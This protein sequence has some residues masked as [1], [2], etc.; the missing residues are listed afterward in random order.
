[1]NTNKDSKYQTAQACLPELAHTRHLQLLRQP[2]DE[3]FNSETDKDSTKISRYH[4]ALA[5]TPKLAHA[6][7]YLLCIA[8]AAHNR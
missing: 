2:S 6:S 7:E 4:A 3:A 1:M 5:C 8:P